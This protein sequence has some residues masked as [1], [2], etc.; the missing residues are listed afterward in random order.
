MFEIYNSIRNIQY[1]LLSDTTKPIWR[2]A[3][4]SSESFSLQTETYTPHNHVIW[5]KYHIG[6]LRVEYP[7]DGHS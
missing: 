7:V 5:S 1:Q 4:S 3:Q 2:R 6:S